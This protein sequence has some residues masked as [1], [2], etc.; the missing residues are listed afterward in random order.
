ML[1]TLAT[2]IIGQLANGLKKKFAPYAMQSI[3]AC[4]TK[5]KER[6][7]NVVQTLRETIDAVSKTVICSYIYVDF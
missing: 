5:F 4:L 1:V 6:K 7:V 3:Q 2:K